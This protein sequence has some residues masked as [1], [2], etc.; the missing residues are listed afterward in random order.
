MCCPKSIEQTNLEKILQ[1]Q[2]ITAQTSEHDG[3]NVEF[4][5]RQE[6]VNDILFELDDLIDTAV[7]LKKTNRFI[8]S[9]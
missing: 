8:N 1:V 5:V 9:K 3:R 4:K 6:N 7:Q 2:R